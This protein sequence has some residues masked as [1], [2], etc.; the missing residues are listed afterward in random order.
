LVVG[1]KGLNSIRRFVLGS[2]PSKII[3]SAPCT[4]HI[5]HTV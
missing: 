4:T 3:H 2:V 5:V 1:S